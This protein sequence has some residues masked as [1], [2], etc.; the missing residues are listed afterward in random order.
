MSRTHTMESI[1]NGNAL[2]KHAR[3]AQKLS[4]VCVK[5]GHLL[6]VALLTLDWL[7]AT[8]VIMML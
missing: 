1:G 7:L 8:E 5:V 4:T 6:E 3:E 2:Q